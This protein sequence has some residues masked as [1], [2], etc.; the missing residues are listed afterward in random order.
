MKRKFNFFIG[1]ALLPL[2]LSPMLSGRS[3]Q[4]Q[5]AETANPP[6]PRSASV[7]PIAMYNSD[8][9]FGFGGKGVVKNRFQKDESLDLILF[10]SSRGEQWYEFTFS[11]PDFE[12]R[13]GRRYP[14]ALDLKLEYDKLLKSSFFGLGNDSRDNSYGFPRE[15]FK[16]E[17]AVSR[18]FTGRF[19]GEC[20]VRFAHYS[21]YGYDPAWRTLSPY[22]PGA[23]E[24]SL[25]AAGLKVRF[26]T[27][28][29][30]IHPRRGVRI[31]VQAEKT[32]GVL[33]SDWGNWKGRLEAS[34]Y[35]PLFHPDH[36]L[37]VRL[38]AQQIN[39]SAPYEE[40]S[41]VGDS[42]TARG[43]KAGR[44]LDKAMALTSVETR[45]HLYRKIGG[46]VFADAGR[47]WPDLGRFSL[48]GWHSDWGAGLRL[49]LKNFVVRL[50]VGNSTEGSR[51]FFMF[52]QVF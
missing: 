22:V 2:L 1:T 16:A 40:L 21:A 46:V 8:I 27:R 9:G 13:Q 48:S 11:I 17:A 50:D 24:T 45:L 31:E 42:W 26:D 4:A 52:G 35:H 3:V 38:W 5:P 32:Y 6:R 41:K 20:L 37:A 36:V 34:A 18:A 23:G 47:V 39:G 30:Q 10:G 44:F 12:I 15:F 25:C 33:G 51:L 14:A 43:Y 28:D 49:Y 19:I 7:F 29:S